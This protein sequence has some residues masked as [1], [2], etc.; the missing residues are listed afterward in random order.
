[1]AN[2]TPLTQIWIPSTD[3]QPFLNPH[4]D[5][6]QYFDVYGN[7]YTISNIGIVMGVLPFKKIGLDLGFDWRDF[8]GKH[9]HPFLFNAKL[10]VPEDAFFKH[11]PAVAAGGYD[12]G[13]EKNLTTFNIVYGLAAKTIWK[14]GR[15]SVGGYAGALG[16]D[17]TAIGVLGFAGH[18]DRGGVLASWDRKFPELWNKL[19]ASIDFQS[20][21]NGYG[22]VNFGASWNFTPT[23]LILLGYD[24]FLVP[25]IRPAINLQL[26]LDVF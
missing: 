4:L 7:G 12:F 17:K 1:M 25:Q 24:I 21:N 3:V 15:F 13:T 26:D 14:L 6:D 8:T 11:M 2:A 18:V 19:W 22:A 23:I 16:G 20:G 9:D 10:G 5:W